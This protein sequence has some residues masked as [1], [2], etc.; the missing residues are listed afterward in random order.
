METLGGDHQKDKEELV[1]SFSSPQRAFLCPL[2]GGFRSSTATVRRSFEE[3]RQRFGNRSTRAEPSERIS[4][5]K[6][7]NAAGARRGEFDTPFQPP[8]TLK[9]DVSDQRGDGLERT[10]AQRK[11]RTVRS[12][13]FGRKNAFATR[14]ERED[15]RNRHESAGRS[16]EV[17]KERRR[18]KVSRISIARF[19]RGLDENTR[20]IYKQN[21]DLI[22]SL[23]I[24]KREF[25]QLQNSKDKLT[26]EFSSITNDR[27][28][29]D[30]LVKE[31]IEKVQRQ[32]KTIKEVRRR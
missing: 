29:N 5:E 3:E 1:R 20:N 4:K 13:I 12:E 16:V 32:Q 14:V 18:G 11:F 21:V 27:E 28:I 26:K 15:S 2:V 8:L 22:E 10:A 30:H 19:R 17:R 31:K 6:R 7:T 23:R 25:E 9:I 24:Y